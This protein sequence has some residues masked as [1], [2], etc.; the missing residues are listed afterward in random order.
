MKQ[1]PN[2]FFAFAPLIFYFILHHLAKDSKHFSL[3]S[4]FSSTFS[5]KLNPL[6]QNT[7]PKLNPLQLPTWLAPPNYSHSF[8]STSL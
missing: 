1:T 4:F 6:K 7:N 2:I 3:F 5:L 8:L